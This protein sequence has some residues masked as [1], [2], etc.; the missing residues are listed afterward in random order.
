MPDITESP[1]IKPKNGQAN[2]M[3]KND[4]NSPMKRGPLPST[5]LAKT[6]LP[7]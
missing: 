6:I 7:T 2:L 5:Q 1:T 3:Q 4:D